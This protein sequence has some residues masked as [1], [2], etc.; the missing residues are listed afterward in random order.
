MRSEEEE[1]EH[2][3]PPYLPSSEEYEEC[4]QRVQELGGSIGGPVLQLDEFPNDDEAHAA[5]FRVF[6]KYG[7]LEKVKEMVEWWNN[8]TMAN[9]QE[10][11]AKE[12]EEEQEKEEQADPHHYLWTSNSGYGET[13]F[14]LAAK[15]AQVEVVSYLLGLEGCDPNYGPKGSFPKVPLLWA[16]TSYSQE[17]FDRRSRRHAET[18]LA[19][20]EA[21]ARCPNPLAPTSALRCAASCG[22]GLIFKL[23]LCYQVSEDSRT[24]A[25]VEEAFFSSEQIQKCA[26]VLP[27]QRSGI[28][29]SGGNGSG[30]GIHHVLQELVASAQRVEKQLDKRPSHQ[31]KKEKEKEKKEKE[32][33]TVVAERGYKGMDKIFGLYNKTI[34]GGT[35]KGYK[36]KEKKKE[37]DAV[38]SDATEEHGKWNEEGERWRIVET[39]EHSQKCKITPLEFACREGYWDVVELMLSNPAV[40]VRLRREQWQTIQCPSQEAEKEGVGE[41]H[42]D[43]ETRLVLAHG[44][45]TALHWACKHDKIDVV[46]QLVACGASIYLRDAC[47]RMPFDMTTSQRTRRI[48]LVALTIW[49]AWYRCADT[50]TQSHR[51]NGLHPRKACLLGLLPKELIVCILNAAF[52]S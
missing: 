4:Q 51:F 31:Q 52:H 49:A 22:S 36:K 28:S 20:L 14:M 1:G 32:K 12:E 26:L 30:N 21:G 34:G 15:Y 45:A 48:Y 5:N 33:T 23:L 16:C 9:Q 29:G 46:E 50:E 19:L 3:R 8:S 27:K 10:D 25:S 13:G 44:R 11:K 17:C 40:R 24:S 2:R 18:V 39:E 6:C 35:K 38:R 42:G 47:G 43:R 7:M 37:P 41:I